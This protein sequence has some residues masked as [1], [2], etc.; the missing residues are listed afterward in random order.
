M[1]EE[2]T[3]DD[4]NFRDRTLAEWQ[5]DFTIELPKIP[6]TSIEVQKALVEW[7]TAY[8]RAYNCYNELIVMANNTENDLNKAKGI[9]VAKKVKEYKADNVGRLPA[10]ELIVE[11][12]LTENEDL[13]KLQYTMNLLEIIKEF[14][15]NNKIKLEKAMPLITNLSY[16]THASDKVSNHGGT[17]GL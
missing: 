2:L 13:A 1:S 5:E 16:M 17:S 11:L 6:S 14:F 9:A 15:E 10:R 3:L 8:Q 7:N 12:V 4:L